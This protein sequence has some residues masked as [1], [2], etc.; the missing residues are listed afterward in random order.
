MSKVMDWLFPAVPY[1]WGTHRVDWFWLL[2]L[3]IVIVVYL[4]RGLS[5]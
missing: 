3:L 1:M 2:A 4:R 5:E